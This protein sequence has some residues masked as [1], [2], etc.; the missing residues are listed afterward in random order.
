M[1]ARLDLLAA[2]L[3]SIAA[4]R[5]AGKQASRCPSERPHVCRHGESGSPS[6]SSSSR[7]FLESDAVASS[8][9]R[10]KHF[11]MACLWE[12]N[13]GGNGTD[14]AREPF[15]RWGESSKISAILQ[16]DSDV[17]AGTYIV[18]YLLS[19]EMPAFLGGVFFFSWWRRSNFP[20]HIAATRT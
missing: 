4:G 1:N 13:T 16:S 17:E 12:P 10:E 20:C 9:V 3:V 18:P 2:Q 11:A 14:S 6:A 5:Q 15:S 8:L 7:H 19:A